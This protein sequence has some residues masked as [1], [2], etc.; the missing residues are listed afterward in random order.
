ML[1]AAGLA[2]AATVT[3]AAVRG[4]LH[5]G[6]VLLTTAQYLLLTAVISLFVGYSSTRAARSLARRAVAK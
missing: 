6:W 3:A 4:P 2:Y 1:A 5:I